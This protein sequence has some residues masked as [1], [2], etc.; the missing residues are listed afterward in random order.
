[1]HAASGGRPTIS[2]L[3]AKKVGAIS[4]GWRPKCFLL[5]AIR[6]S[7]SDNSRRATFNTRVK[8]G[9][10]NQ[11]SRFWYRSLRSITLRHKGLNGSPGL[12]VSASPPCSEPGENTLARSATSI[13]F[14]AAE[15][16]AKLP[17]SVGPRPGPVVGNAARP[18]DAR[19]S[20]SA[21]T[22]GRGC[23]GGPAE[24]CARLHFGK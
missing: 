23:D 18:G 22:V 17:S 15:A 14:S 8:Q 4:G 6:L 1:M 13:G 11:G 12:R 5:W 10:G 3:P 2:L 21:D 19:R 20:R 16:D 24:V 7:A 9:D